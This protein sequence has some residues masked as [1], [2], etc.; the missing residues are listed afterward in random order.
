[1]FSTQQDICLN[2][3]ENE[4]NKKFS[5]TYLTE[6]NFVIKCAK[7]PEYY[8]LQEKRYKAFLIVNKIGF[9]PSFGGEYNKYDCVEIENKDKHLMNSNFCSFENVIN[10]HIQQ[11]NEKFTFNYFVCKDDSAKFFLQ[12]ALTRAVK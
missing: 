6:N 1:M 8:I 3:D 2:L 7:G 11:R 5:L 12:V 4:K 9:C 10:K